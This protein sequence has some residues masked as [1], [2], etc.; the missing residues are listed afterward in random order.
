MPDR[1]ILVRLTLIGLLATALVSEVAVQAGRGDQPYHLPRATT[2]PAATAAPR[3][4]PANRLATEVATVLARPLFRAGRR[5]PPGSSDAPPTA[6]PRAI[7]PR[8]SGIVVSSAGGEA[9]FEDG[10][11]PVLAHVGDRLGAYTIAS[12][13]AGNVIVDGPDGVQALVPTFDKS[14]VVPVQTAQVAPPPQQLTNG[15]T[16]D[17]PIPPPPTL[18][19]LMDQRRAAHAQ[20]RWPRP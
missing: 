13:A 7:M 1:S 15:A 18:R 9:I 20:E 19:S 2:A 8:L 11:K 6:S 14:R 17:L 3:P 10:G 16:A 5:P 4:P 12:I